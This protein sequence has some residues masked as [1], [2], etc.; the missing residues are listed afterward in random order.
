MLIDG[1]NHLGVDLLFYL[2]GEYPYAQDVHGMVHMADGMG[3]D[4]WIV[5]PMLSYVAMDFAAMRQGRIVVPE[6]GEVPY[7]F[8]NERMLR[9]INDHFPDHADRCLPF[10]MV[11]PGRDPERQIETLRTLR[12]Q[13]RIWGIKIQPTII[14]SP[15]TSL[16][17]K[18]RG[19]LELAREWD[20]PFLIHASI[21]AADHWSQADDIIRI[22]EANPDVRFALAHSARFD[23]P[24]LDR[25]A[26]LPNAWFDC[27][28]HVIHCQCAVDG[29]DNITV[30]ARRVVTDYSDPVAV[31]LTLWQLYPTKLIWGSDSPFHTY[32]GAGA[33]PGSFMR[34]ISTYRGELDVLRA[35]PKAA[36]EAIADRNTCAFLGR[37]P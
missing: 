25:V 15:I 21:A 33:S 9:E 1:H 32:I 4:R 30:P 35:L 5:F 27:S 19:F 14:Q 26:A 3:V 17:T 6:R 18:G 8:E 36:V 28:A 23:Q 34:L 22:A 37:R 13:R 20:V 24:S 11:D 10:V 12:A 29:L 31:L 2:R 7:Q 16:M